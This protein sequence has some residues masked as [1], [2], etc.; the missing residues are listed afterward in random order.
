LFYCTENIVNSYF[1]RLG[2]TFAI[3]GLLFMAPLIAMGQFST[4]PSASHNDS[5]ANKRAAIPAAN[6]GKRSDE[7]EGSE[8]GGA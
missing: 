3:A 8:P 7:P 2:S 1:D 5:I 6:P 4:R